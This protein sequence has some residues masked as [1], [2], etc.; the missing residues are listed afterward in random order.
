LPD[1]GS[2]ASPREKD[3][4][5]KTARQGMMGNETSR[6]SAISSARIAGNNYYYKYILADKASTIETSGS[7]VDFG[8]RRL[9]L[10]T[11]R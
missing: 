3:V 9:A 10:R 2:I 4:G 5:H 1:I 8:N 11:T 7:E 6:N